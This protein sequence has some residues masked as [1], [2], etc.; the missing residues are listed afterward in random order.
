M[1]PAR[2]VI[3]AT[4]VMP[5][6]VLMP[7]SVE[8]QEPQQQKGSRIWATTLLHGHRQQQKPGNSAVNSSIAKTTQRSWTL[9]Q[10]GVY[11]NRYVLDTEGKPISAVKPGTA[12]TSVISV[13]PATEWHQKSLT[14]ATAVT[15]EEAGTQAER[16][17]WFLWR[18]QKIFKIWFRL[19]S[20]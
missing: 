12:V 7:L 6:T 3:S 9:Q 10:Q 14:P 13:T 17:L 1:T 16:S 5:T 15:P 11:N 2:A 18:F 20:V 19:N 8:Q 4:T